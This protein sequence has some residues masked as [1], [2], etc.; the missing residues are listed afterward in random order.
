M[1]VNGWLVVSQDSVGQRACFGAVSL[2]ENAAEAV[3]IELKLLCSSSES[4]TDFFYIQLMR[5]MSLMVHPNDGSLQL[6]STSQVLHWSVI[7]DFVL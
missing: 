7:L 4:D 1:S 3:N 6:W 2:Y 5:K